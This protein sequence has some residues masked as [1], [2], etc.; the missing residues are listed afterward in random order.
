MA[1]KN[2][3]AAV[4]IELTENGPL[5]VKGLPTL[6]DHRGKAVEMK[7]DVI[8]LCR[9]GKSVNKP[10]C[11]GTHRGAGFSGAREISKPLDRRRDYPGKTITIHDNRTI[12]A[13]AGACVKE[14]SSVFIK[15]GRPWIDPDGANVAAIVAVINKCPSGALSYTASDRLTRDDANDPAITIAKDGPY[16]VTG[17]IALQGELSP[18][19][20]ERYSLC[21]CGAS[22]NKPFCDGT[23]HEINFKG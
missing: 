9:C 4:T 13:H 15:D 22:K 10:F 23:H 18:P 2:G 1:D 14:L 21:R 17:P 16:D 19:S 11:D 8:A 6:M 7:K 12:C 5:I 3:S 20:G